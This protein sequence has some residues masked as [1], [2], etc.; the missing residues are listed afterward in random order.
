MAVPKTA[1]VEDFESLQNI[2][3]VVGE[4]PGAYQVN[5][6]A[7]MDMLPGALYRQLASMDL[8]GLLLCEGGGGILYPF[9][10]ID[11]KDAEILYAQTRR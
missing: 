7:R 2:Y 5:I 4:T 1:G 8:A 6:A 11:Q 3:R 10:V 9:R